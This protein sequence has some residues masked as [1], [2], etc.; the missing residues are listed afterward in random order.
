MSAVLNLLSFGLVVVSNE[1]GRHIAYSVRMNYKTAN[2]FC[3]KHIF[4]KLII[5]AKV[6][7][8]LFSCRHVP[9]K[10]TLLEYLLLDLCLKVFR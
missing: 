5:A 7:G 10:V 6:T 2:D 1:P 4:K 9:A 3:V 8:V